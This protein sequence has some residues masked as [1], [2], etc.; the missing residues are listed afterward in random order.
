MNPAARLL[1]LTA[2]VMCAVLAAFVGRRACRLQ[3]QQ[4]RDRITV[5]FS[6]PSRPG[7]VK[8][9]L[10]QGGVTVKAADVKEVV[11]ESPGIAERERSAP[12]AASSG[13]VG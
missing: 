10:I 12:P 9:R 13:C 4:N 7:T 1:R 6:D 8:V 2:P 11:V 3:A 5:P